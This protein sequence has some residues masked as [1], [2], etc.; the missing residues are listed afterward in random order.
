AACQFKAGQGA[1]ADELVQQALAEAGQRLP[2]IFSILVELIRIK[3]KPVLKKRFE[4]EFSAM[5]TERTTPAPVLACLLFAAS[6]RLARVKYTGQKSHEKLLTD[7]LDQV[8]PAALSE[9][10]LS[11]AC[12]ALWALGD[13]QGVRRYAGQG[14]K[15]FKVTPQFLI[16]EADTYL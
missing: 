2:V 7:Y 5:L 3:A 8:P 16:Y 10:Q 14:K 1:R 15:R 4:A 12:A 6:L 9:C 13:F 11:E